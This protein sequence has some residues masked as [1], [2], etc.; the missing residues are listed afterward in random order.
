VAEHLLKRK[1]QRTLRA[2]PVLAEVC[3]LQG[4]ARHQHLHRGVEEARVAEVCEAD[5][6]AKRGAASGRCGGGWRRRG[7]GKQGGCMGREGLGRGGGRRRCGGARP[8][9]AGG[10]G[11]AR[12]RPAAEAPRGA[13]W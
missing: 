12:A 5:D 13:S 2:A 4:G 6:A 8:W 3:L 10:G 11:T 1:T 9:H 7:L